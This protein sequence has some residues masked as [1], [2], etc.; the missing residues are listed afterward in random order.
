[1]CHVVTILMLN[2]CPQ[3]VH[4]I[5]QRPL[6]SGDHLNGIDVNNKGKVLSYIY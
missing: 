3:Y 2:V 4:C 6:V 1:M 5:E